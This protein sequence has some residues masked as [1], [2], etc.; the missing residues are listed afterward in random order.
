M[1]IIT[2]DVK[3]IDHLDIVKEMIEELE[4]LRFF[5]KEAGLYFENCTPFMCEGLRKKYD[6]LKEEQTT[7][8]DLHGMC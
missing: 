7:E 8:E 5:Y 6:K 4:W 1:D 2:A 3:T